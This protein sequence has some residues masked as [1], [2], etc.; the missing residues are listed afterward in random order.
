MDRARLYGHQRCHEGQHA[1]A[2]DDYGDDGQMERDRGVEDREPYGLRQHESQQV[3]GRPA[4]ALSTSASPRMTEAMP[5]PSAP[6]D[7]ISPIS[8]RR[9]MTALASEALTVR[10]EMKMMSAVTRTMSRLILPSRFWLALATCLTVL[11]RAP[12][13]SSSSDAATWSRFWPSPA[14]TLTSTTLTFPVRPL[15]D[16][17]WSRS[18]ITWLSS[19]P[20]ELGVPVTASVL[21]VPPSFTVKRI[22]GLQAQLGRHL[23]AEDGAMAALGRD[24]AL[25]APPGVDPERLL[26]D[27]AVDDYLAAVH[28]GQAVH[29]GRVTGQREIDRPIE[30][31]QL[32]LVDM[33]LRLKRQAEVAGSAASF[34]SSRMLLPK[35]VSSRSFFSPMSMARLSSAASSDRPM[36]SV[37]TISSALPGR[38]LSDLVI[39]RGNISIL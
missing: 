32:R 25:H 38:C 36:I 21:T 13:T 22:A 31:R 39:K 23:F 30:R 5:R 27:G 26:K 17:A 11:A 35:A 10:P 1:Y 6:R 33:A 37:S 28:I 4:T 2:D 18:M 7:F 29:E 3:S 19:E 20:P 34:G 9:S 12:G 16:W 24:L 14:S 15:I 8:R